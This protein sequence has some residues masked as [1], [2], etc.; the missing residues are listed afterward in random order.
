MMTTPVS[1]GQ[2]IDYTTRTKKMV[3]GDFVYEK[4]VISGTVVG[5]FKARRYIRVRDDGAAKS[6]T[7]LITERDIVKVY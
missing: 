7:W 6:D 3:D 5:F 2:H 4:R 1:K